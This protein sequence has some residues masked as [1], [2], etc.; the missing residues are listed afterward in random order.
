[1][2]GGRSLLICSDSLEGGLGA[3][4]RRHAEWFSGRSWT[5]DVASGGRAPEAGLAARYTSLPMPSTAR[6]L[7]RMASAAMALRGLIRVTRPE[8]VHCHG[9]RSLL[10]ARLARWQ[11]PFVTL[12]TLGTTPDD[13]PGYATVRRWALRTVPMVAAAAFSA[14]PGAPASWSFVPHA[15]P[16]LARLDRLAFPP[17]STVPTFLWV[18]R[19]DLVKRAEVFVRAI[20]ELHSKQ[21]VRGLI[22]GDGPTRPSIEALIRQLH[23]P[24]E[25]LGI[26][27]PEPLLAESWGLGL[28][29]TSEALTFAIQEAMWAGRAVVCSP[30]PGPAWLVGDDGLLAGDVAAAVTAF[31]RLCDHATAAAL[32]EQ[33]SVRV[34]SLISPDDPWPFMEAAYSSR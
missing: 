12:H 32:G 11:A 23:A 21:P 5:V 30:I 7:D 14:S 10:I 33:A 31:Q 4:V 16:R 13:P 25:L 24:I 34:R 2:S 29:S 1:M 18:G 26:T 17:A 22:A 15:S 28:F 3:V 20:A 19:M 6:R 9:L 27:D 8:V